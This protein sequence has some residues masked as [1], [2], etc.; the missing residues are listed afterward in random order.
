MFLNLSIQMALLQVSKKVFDNKKMICSINDLIARL[1]NGLTRKLTVIFVLNTKKTKQILNLL[2]DNGFIYNY[3][4]INKKYCKVFLKYK[5]RFT[6]SKYK[7]ISKPS[8]QKYYSLNIIK[9]LYAKY[10]FTAISTNKGLVSLDTAILKKLGGE[11]WFI[12]EKR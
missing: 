5:N 8:W 4:V 1:N 12:I 2:C 10:S 6:F 11:V 7:C 9:K 3:I